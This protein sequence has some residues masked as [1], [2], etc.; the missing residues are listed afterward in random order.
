MYNHSPDNYV[1]PFCLVSQ[2]IENENL[3]TDQKDVI[4]R[5]NTIT[6]F[7]AAGCWKNNKGHVLII[8][9]QHYENIYDLPTSLSA[10]IHDFEKEVALAFKEVYKCDGVSSRQHNEP[11][12]NQDVWHYHLHVFPRYE[13]D[14]LYKTDREFLP[15]QERHLFARRLRQY[16]ESANI[17]QSIKKSNMIFQLF[18]ASVIIYKNDR[19]L[20]QKRKDNSCWGYHGGRVELGEIVEEAAKRELFE[21]TG[22][23]ANSLKLFGVFSGPELHHIY[24]DGNE[25]YIIDTVYLC[26]DFSGTTIF[27]EEECLDLQWFAFDNIP[28]KLSPPIIPALK[29]FIELHRSK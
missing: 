27:Q 16:F 19:I 28:E 25:V 29:K 9:N 26:D 21:E 15:P 5:D 4:Y 20:L 2:G 22:L 10:R 14:N 24:P 8:P 3:L 11:S 7:I 12:G 18:G 17:K 23:T 1:C 13:D 6:A